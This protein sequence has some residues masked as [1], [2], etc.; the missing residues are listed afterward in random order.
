MASTE[1]LL[2]GRLI[3]PKLNRI[4]HGGETIQIEPRVMDVLNVLVQR[5]GQPVTREELFDTVWADTVVTD[6]T[7]TRCIGELRKIFGDDARNPRIIET[8]PRV[9]YRLIQQPST[10]ERPGSSRGHGVGQ[11]VRGS[12]TAKQLWIGAVALVGLI[13]WQFLRAE[14]G[15]NEP[16]TPLPL[17]TYPGRESM[18]A[19]SPDGRYFAFVWM[20]EQTDLFVRGVD[21]SEPLQLTTDPARERNPVWSPDGGSLAFVRVSGDDCGIFTMPAL[22]GPE[23]RVTSCSRWAEID[24]S[25]DGRH[26]AVTGESE[27]GTYVIHLVD[28]ET[29]VSTPIEYDRTG[30]KG[31]Y[32][33]RFSP[34]GRTIAFRRS[35]GEGQSDLFTIST[36][37][38]DVRR[39]THDDA[40]LVGHAWM[41]DGHSLVFSSNRSGPF[42]LWRVSARGGTPEWMPIADEAFDPAVAEDVVAYERWSVDTDLYLGDEPLCP[43][44]SADRNPDLSADGRRLVFVSRRSGAYGIWTCDLLD[45]RADRLTEHGGNPVVAPAWSPDGRRVAYSVFDEGQSDV[46]VID[47]AWASSRG[48]TSPPR[49]LTDRPSNEVYAAWSA[50][51]R[52]IYYASDRTGRMEIWKQPVGG[53][54]A[55][56]LTTEGGLIAREF[57][58]QL[59]FTREGESGLYR[60]P[61]SGGPSELVL[62]DFDLF[63][64]TSWSVGQDAFYYLDRSDPSNVRVMRHDGER[65]EIIRELGAVPVANGLAVAG[66]RIVSVRLERQEGD[67]MIVRR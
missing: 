50:D 66:E 31:D 67:L 26:L 18:V 62:R 30:A 28:V 35:L 17:T 55:V 64:A 12:L 2:D 48:P 15:G 44:T 53:G 29:G 16:L 65:S 3:Q 54:D 47:D 5:A 20:Q 25:P 59:Y 8:I 23:R 56:Q 46:Y 43:S 58:G 6:D 24:W 52:W 37:G 42:S 4:Q 14:T 19:F 32:A 60:I 40:A 22:G 21:A 34:D 1:Y 7:L 49:I 10:P 11:A 33:P 13:A 45:A 57:D 41:P 51:G 63:N 9:G 36:G 61:L 27:E 39:L 38:G